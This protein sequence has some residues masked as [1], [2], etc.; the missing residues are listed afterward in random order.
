MKT[1]IRDVAKLAN[2]S[3][4][5]VSR[6][7]NNTKPVSGEVKERVLQAINETSFKPNIVARSLAS[8]K[9]NMIGVIFTDI[10]NM[11]FSELVAGIERTANYYNYNTILCTSR[12][13]SKVELENLYMLK[14]KGVDGIIFTLHKSIQEG[15]A[16]FIEKNDIP[17]ISLDKICRGTVSIGIDNLKES[18]DITNYIIS[19]GHRNIAYIGANYGD[20]ET[21][22]LRFQGYL[23]ALNENNLHVKPS[24]MVEGDFTIESGYNACEKIIMLNEKVSSIICASDEMAFGA[25]NCLADKGIKVPEDISVA[26]F[27]DIKFSKFTRPRLTTVHQPITE[28][29]ELAT[30]TLIN[31]IN[32][33]SKRYDERIVIKGGIIVRDS[34]REI[35]I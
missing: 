11:Y 8:K 1:T 35:S 33:K 32:K 3:I 23:N 12:K 31:N 34:T 30:K 6:V 15:V 28:I 21:E 29:G 2:V 16:K 10:S 5:T 9:S 24:M 19:I 25:M 14:E 20:D 7:I 26:G 18:Y 22:S 4:A 17:T 13:D 27:D